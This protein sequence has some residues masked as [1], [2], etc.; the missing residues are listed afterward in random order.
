MKDKVEI[1]K[2]SDEVTEYYGEEETIMQLKEKFERAY[3][4]LQRELE[5][6]QHN[7]TDLI[8]T[9]LEARQI[10]MDNFVYETQIASE[11]ELR[12]Y[13]QEADLAVKSFLEKIKAIEDEMEG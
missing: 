12:E 7:I 2:V 13:A 3:W 9:D 6:I 10:E 4:T 11:R 5:S 8:G 1:V